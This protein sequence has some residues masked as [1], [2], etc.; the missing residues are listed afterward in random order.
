MIINE[1]NHSLETGRPVLFL[2]GFLESSNMWRELTFSPLEIKPIFIDLNGHGELAKLA[3]KKIHSIKQLAEEIYEVLKPLNLNSYDCAG[4]S[5][6]G[7]VAL[8]LAKLD[9]R[10]QKLVLFHSNHWSDTEE[11]KINRNRVVKIVNSNFNLFLNEAIP[12]LFYNPKPYSKEI[13]SIIKEAQSILPQTVIDCSY[14]MR[15]RLD[16]GNF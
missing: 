3:Y 5:L 11:K 7:Y 13:K 15:D 9:S 16:N 1:S 2:H 8:E 12:N 14:A 4:H 10:L 6:G